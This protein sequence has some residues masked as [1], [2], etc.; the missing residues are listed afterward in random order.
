[1][2]KGLPV[3]VITHFD[4]VE[5]FLSPYKVRWLSLSPHK[6]T[7]AGVFPYEIIIILKIMMMTM[8]QTIWTEEKNL[9]ACYIMKIVLK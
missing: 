2:N 5:N 3:V 6:D 9:L 1:M 7:Q 4:D 8:K